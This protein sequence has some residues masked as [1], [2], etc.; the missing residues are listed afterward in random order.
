LAKHAAL[1]GEVKGTRTTL[2]GEVNAL[3]HP[4]GTSPHPEERV[5]MPELQSQFY[6]SQP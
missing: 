6:S 1:K 2:K 4:L 3:A 5:I